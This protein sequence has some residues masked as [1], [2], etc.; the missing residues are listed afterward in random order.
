MFDALYVHSFETE[1][2]HHIIK[3][4]YGIYMLKLHS[5][6]ITLSEF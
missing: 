2:C 1:N 4:E 3:I 5:T 6:P